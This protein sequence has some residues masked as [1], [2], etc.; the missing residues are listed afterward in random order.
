MAKI[1]IVHPAENNLPDFTE[2]I[3]AR[4]WGLGGTAQQPFYT[5]S[6]L[7][8]QANSNLWLEIY[9]SVEGAQIFYTRNFLH[10]TPSP[11]PQ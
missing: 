4:V 8:F 2:T 11:L 6:G 9:Y 5:G 3:E 7:N 10:Y 1:E